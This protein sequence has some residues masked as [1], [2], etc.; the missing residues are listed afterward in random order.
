VPKRKIFEEMMEGIAAMKQYR[1]GKLT[2][3]SCHIS[4]APRPSTDSEL[5][6]DTGKKLRSSRAE[7]K[8]R[9]AKT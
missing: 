9:R 3:R 5:F 6:K 1:D 4:P 8:S 2:L 7:G